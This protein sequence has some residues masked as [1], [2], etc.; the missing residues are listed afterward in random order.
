MQALMI[1]NSILLIL[2]S[3]LLVR[4]TIKNNELQQKARNYDN[5]IK[6]LSLHQDHN[7]D[8]QIENNEIKKIN[9]NLQEQIKNLEAKNQR[10]QSNQQRAEKKTNTSGKSTV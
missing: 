6:T 5:I 4:K 8:L 7:F 1:I 2:V 9:K 10:L 3:L